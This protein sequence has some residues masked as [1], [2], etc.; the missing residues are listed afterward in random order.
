MIQ[1]EQVYLQE[2]DVICWNNPNFLYSFLQIASITF[3]YQNDKHDVFQFILKDVHLY[4]RKIYLS[5]IE[6]EEI[7]ADMEALL[8]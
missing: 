4:A 1:V 2:I 8:V 3:Y 7:S 5:T 6:R